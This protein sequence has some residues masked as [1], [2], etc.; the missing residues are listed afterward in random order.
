M[1]AYNIYEHPDFELSSKNAASLTVVVAGM[2]SVII[3]SS[4][5][6][7]FWMASLKARPTM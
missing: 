5:A 2:L 3:T 6:V 7:Y 4:I 1:R